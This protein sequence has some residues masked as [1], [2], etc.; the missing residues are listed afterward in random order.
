MALNFAASADKL[1]LAAFAI[2]S[3]ALTYAAWVKD[4]PLANGGPRI[5]ENT[6]PTTRFFFGSDGSLIF[7]RLWTGTAEWTVSYASMGSPN[8]ANWHHVAVTYDGTSS[9]NTPIFYVDGASFAPTS[10]TGV[11]PTGSLNNTSNVMNLAN[12]PT[13]ARNLG[14][15]DHIG[16]YN[17]VLTQANIQSLL[18]TPHFASNQFANWSFGSLL[19]TYTDLS[20]NGRTATVSGAP[21]FVAGPDLTAGINIAANTNFTVSALPKVMIP[22]GVNVQIGF[23]ATVDLQVGTPYPGGPGAGVGGAHKG[24]ISLFLRARKQR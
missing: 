10:T 6:T 15:A 11:P 20:G 17:A 24:R 3:P 14:T 19:A 21:T 2:P 13:S 8:W 23:N 18:T 22:I 16:I 4:P 12:R 9:A 7:Q 5:I 1:T